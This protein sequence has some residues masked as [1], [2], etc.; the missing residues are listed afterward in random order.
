MKYL[1]QHKIF[2]D[3]DDLDYTDEFLAKAPSI[4]TIKD[5]FVAEFEDN[6]NFDLLDVSVGRSIAKLK[7]IRRYANPEQTGGAL[8]FEYKVHIKQ[9]FEKKYTQLLQ[10]LGDDPVNLRY[11]T[12]NITLDICRTINSKVLNKLAQ[13]YSININYKFIE[14]TDNM[15]DDFET[16]MDIHFYFRNIKTYE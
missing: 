14:F 3:L 5:W 12:A 15:R 6:N 11:Q 8:Y 13:K 10:D 4:D 9:D 16:D 7:S 2:E 1:K